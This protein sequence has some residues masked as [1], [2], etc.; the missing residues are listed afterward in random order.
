MVPISLTTHP[1][2]ILHA[3]VDCLKQKSVLLELTAALTEGVVNG[4]ELKMRQALRSQP[5]TPCPSPA[6]KGPN[7]Q[8]VG[9]PQRIGW[10]HFREIFMLS[11]L[12]QEDVK[13][14]KV[15]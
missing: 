14:L 8:S 2:P 7:T 13:T 1:L 4:K 9:G 15:S 6:A 12:S 10:P 5:G 11:A 3:Q